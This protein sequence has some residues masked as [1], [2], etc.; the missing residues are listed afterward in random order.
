[1]NISRVRTKILLSFSV[2]IALSFILSAWISYVSYSFRT[3]V[4]NLKSY[5]TPLLVVEENL[6]YNIAQRIALARAYLLYGD[7]TYLDRFKSYTDASRK[8]QDELLALT[9]DPELAK[10]VKDSSE[11]RALVESKVFQAYDAGRQAEAARVLKDELEPMAR[12]I[13]DTLDKV[14][15]KRQDEIGQVQQSLLSD[16]VAL[17]TTA[18]MFMLLI[19]AIGL[20]FAFVIAARISKPI[21]A[22]ERN[23]SLIAAGDLRVDK[24]QESG[25]DEIGRL[26]VAANTMSVQLRSLIASVSSSAEQ[27]A[28]T[29]EQLSAGSQQTTA[30]AAH[31]AESIEQ[32]ASG[33]EN[34][35]AKSGESAVAMEEIA[36]G[37]ELIADSSQSVADS[38]S[39]M[40]A[41][42][43]EG[44]TAAQDAVERIGVL[45]ETAGNVSRVIAQ[46]NTQAQEIGGIA[47][48]I[49]DIAAQ[50]NLLALN[51][52]IEAARAGEHGSGFAVVASE[53]RKLAEQSGESAK[54]IAERIEHIQ[55][56]SARAVTAM[57]S[58]LE[59]VNRSADSVKQLGARFSQILD[60]SRSV[61]RQVEEVSASAEEM[62]AS[63]EEVSASID[64]MAKIARDTSLSTQQV[65]AATQEQT[66][67]MEEI[68]ASSQHLTEMAQKLQEY[69]SKFK[70]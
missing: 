29:S 25:K 19:V 62:S 5:E 14:T 64:E 66:A 35:S 34:Q 65:V 54:E 30:A 17:A 27:V 56:S 16:T 23:L 37:I 9:S 11:W 43:E 69:A 20:T 63:T 52:A 3:K 42:A 48:L 67:S 58:G 61:S 4:D 6:R 51:A 49:A 60:A 2:I 26:L 68:A 8:L 40:V 28:A 21:E 59:E 50:T 7:K 55:L 38:A 31:V 47:K 12:T 22:V 33:A 32:V 10:L 24:L 45:S 41:N 15:D 18:I 57:D 70:L 36:K 46:L 13:M 1:M 39:V 53:V 44:N